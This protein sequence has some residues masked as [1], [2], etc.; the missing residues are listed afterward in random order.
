M[1]RYAM[2]ESVELD[3]GAHG[4]IVEIHGGANPP[5]Y[6]VEVFNVPGSMGDG[7]VT[8]RENGDRLVPIDPAGLAEIFR[9]KPNLAPFEA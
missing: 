1:P 3:G 7:V 6:E 8:M 5:A 4:A 9:Q 2:F